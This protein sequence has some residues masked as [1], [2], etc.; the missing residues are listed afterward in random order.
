MLVVSGAVCWCDD[1]DEALQHGSE[2]QLR[3]LQL[4]Y[5][6][7]VVA[8]RQ[9]FLAAFQHARETDRVTHSSSPPPSSTPERPTG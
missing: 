5:G 4:K 3:Q 1:D 6:A 8:E 2:A 9:E 7:R